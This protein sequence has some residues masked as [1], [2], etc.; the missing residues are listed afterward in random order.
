VICAESDFIDQMNI[1]QQ[2]EDDTFLSKTQFLEQ[3]DRLN[4][5]SFYS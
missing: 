5:D 2:I 4:H 3:G 1:F